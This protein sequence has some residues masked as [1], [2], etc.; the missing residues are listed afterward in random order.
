[1]VKSPH[2]VALVTGGTTGIGFATAQEF[3]KR[4][5]LVVVTGNNPTTLAA[6]RNRLP[7][8][9]VVLQA[10]SS[11]IASA[12]TVAEELRTRFS[13]VDAVTFNAGIG[14]RRPVDHPA[15]GD[16]ILQPAAVAQRRRAAAASR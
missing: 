13:K 12:D 1:M 15:A 10:D 4:G 14:A 11:R 8:D 3:L 7:S 16:L 2:P 5:H 9:V 6:A